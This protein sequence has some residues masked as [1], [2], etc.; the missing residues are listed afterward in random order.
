M[1]SR[2]EDRVRFGNALGIDIKGMSRKQLKNMYDQKFPKLAKPEKKY[3]RVT[4]KVKI[5]GGEVDISKMPPADLCDKNGR[6]LMGGALIAR[7][8]KLEREKGAPSV[9]AEEV[10]QTALPIAESSEVEIRVQAIESKVDDMAKLV[11]QMA[12]L[13]ASQQP[14]S[15]TPEK[16]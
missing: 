9:D 2:F 14:A 8:E 16:A 7:V 12:T 11:Q 6:P 3:T 4:S 10:L 13:V 15:A 1:A 5:T